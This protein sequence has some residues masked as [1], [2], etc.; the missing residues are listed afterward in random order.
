[1]ALIKSTKHPEG[2]WTVF[3]LQMFSMVGF[4]MLFS[5]LVLYCTHV[6]NF[7]TQRAYDIGDAFN[8]QVFAMSVFGGYLSSKFLGYRYAFIVSAIMGIFGLSLILTTNHLAFYIGLGAYTLAQATFIPSLNVLLSMLYEQGDNRR[9]SGFLLSY[10]G[11]NIGA[12]FASLFSGPISVKFGYHAAFFVGLFFAVLVL[13]NYVLHQ[14]KFRPAKIDKLTREHAEGISLG[15]KIAGTII[16]LSFIPLIATL[17]R[18]PQW[19]N[20]VLILLGISSTIFTIIIARRYE[21][22]VRK[23][24]YVFLLLCFIS[25]FFWSLYLLAPTVLPLF[26]DRNVDRHFFSWII[27]TA[28]F[29]AINPFVIITAGPLFSILWMQLA[30]RNITFSPAIKFSIGLALMGCGYL[31]L[32]L[33]IHYHNS[34]GFILGIWMV[35]SYFLQTIGELFVGP[36]GYSMIGSLVPFEQEGFMQGIWQLFTG[37][38]GVWTDY[39][40]TLTHR[41]VPENVTN[42]LLTNHDFMFTFILC[43]SITVVVGIL[44]SIV[45][46][47]IKH[48]VKEPA[49]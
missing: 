48:M 9:D 43:G 32:A 21:G 1:M 6:L 39:L 7:P 40:A 29:S 33:G 18:F 20:T 45:A 37:V 26:T 10:V 5:L 41:H 2:V 27:P 46:P 42:P 15:K 16:L 3:F 13:I 38:A 34:L 30:R 47:W 23:R 25:L 44:T 17:M 12:F 8:A 24:I 35:F 11:M 4:S 49:I 22:I 14:Y 36:I 28:S 31:A 19:N